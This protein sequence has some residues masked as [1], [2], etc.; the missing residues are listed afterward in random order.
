MMVLQLFGTGLEGELKGKPEDEA[1]RGS[2]DEDEDADSNRAD[3]AQ[4]RSRAKLPMMR[5]AKRH[6]TWSIHFIP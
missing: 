6:V 4:A 2:E 5:N 1:I 3:A